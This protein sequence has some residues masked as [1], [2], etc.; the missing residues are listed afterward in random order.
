[1]INPS[2]ARVAR[3]LGAT[4]FV[5]AAEEQVDADR[6]QAVGRCEHGNSSKARS[7][8][9]RKLARPKTNRSCRMLVHGDQQQHLRASDWRSKVRE[10]G[11]GFLVLRGHREER[12]RGGRIQHVRSS[13]VHGRAMHCRQQAG[14]NLHSCHFTR[15]CTDAQYFS[16]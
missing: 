5:V 4:R 12:S 6:V 14:V 1:M 2:G 11:R 13:T 8:P 3:S 16:Y 7:V 15:A 9:R 10:D